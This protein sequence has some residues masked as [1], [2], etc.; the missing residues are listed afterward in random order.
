MSRN[1]MDACTPGPFYFAPEKVSGEKI[2]RA[3]GGS[4]LAFG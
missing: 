4:A 3:V 1:K 2:Y